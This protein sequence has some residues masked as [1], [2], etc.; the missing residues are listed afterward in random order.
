[1]RYDYKMKLAI[2]P[3]SYVVAVS[4][5]VDSMVLLDLLAHQPALQLTV[6][7][8]DH[9]IRAESGADR[10][11]VA[12]AA[13]A[14]GLP[15]VYET[16]HLGPGASEAVARQVRYTFLRRVQQQVGAQAII[17][18]HHQDDVLET[19]IINLL[20]GTGRRG[21]SSLQST[22]TLLRPLLDQPKAALINYARQHSLTWH[23]DSTNQDLHYLRNY[24]RLQLVAKFS[25]AQRRQWLVV[26]A[27]FKE[28]NQQIDS[29]VADLL[30]AQP[31]TQLNRRW[32]INLP[33]AVAREAMA[34]W[35]RQND[36]RTFD[37]PAIERL[38]TA[39]KA[40]PPGKRV[41]ALQHYVILVGNDYLT[42]QR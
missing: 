15:F 29:L 1:M 8:L 4:G 11:L 39:A 41:D 16:A 17:T 2:T 38:T 14:Y 28:L 21:I 26:V 3:G 22:P 27:R 36:L 18:A 34:A 33:Y 10:R 9:G 35:L 40:L 23:Q 12:Q 7:H 42:L 20:R 24:V 5:G 25:P 32:F 37:Q 6:A 19:A 31:T 13:A 30:T